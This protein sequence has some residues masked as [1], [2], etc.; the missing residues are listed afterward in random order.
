MNPVYSTPGQMHAHIHI[1]L[2]M[3]T[4]MPPHTAIHTH[5]LEL[6][7]YTHM[8]HTVF[9]IMK[10]RL[11]NPPLVSSF[12]DFQ[13]SAMHRGVEGS[14]AVSKGVRKRQGVKKNKT[15]NPR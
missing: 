11:G 8:P 14:L 13:C 3:H 10:E 4:N 1:C 6:L 5:A 2:V 15:Q 12:S 7:S 9:A